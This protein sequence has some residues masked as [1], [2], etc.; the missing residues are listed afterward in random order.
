M[1]EDALEIL[2]RV[3][4]LKEIAETYKE[5]CEEDRK[6][7][8]DTLKTLV[9]EIRKRPQATIPDSEIEKM[10]SAIRSA[11]AAA[12]D[13]SG[14][15]ESFAN[16]VAALLDN[17]I[18]NVLEKKAESVVGTIKVEHTHNHWNRLGQFASSE[19][20]EK[21]IT[22]LAW[23]VVILLAA[24]VIIHLRITGVITWSWHDMF[25]DGLQKV[26][27]ERFVK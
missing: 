16:K 6:T 19:T 27:P 26:H 3:P 12:P 15:A 5:M 10:K 23:T 18:G 21:W 2:Q 4:E 7:L 25:W 20:S 1:A 22:G 9:E 13:M 11:R 24:L 8:R 14:Q 17:K